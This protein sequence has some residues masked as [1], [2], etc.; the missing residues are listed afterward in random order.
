MSVH[1]V[2]TVDCTPYYTLLLQRAERQPGLAWPY[3]ARAD[4]TRAGLGRPAC[5]ASSSTLASSWDVAAGWARAQH[6]HPA[7]SE[8]ED[9]TEALPLTAGTDGPRRGV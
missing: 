2:L 4:G 9:H 8:R 5:A 3:R 7:A 6:Q 1:S